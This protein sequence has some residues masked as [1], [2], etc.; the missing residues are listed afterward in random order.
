MKASYGVAK[1]GGYELWLDAVAQP[2]IVFYCNNGLRPLPPAPLSALR[3]LVSLQGLPYSCQM[4]PDVSH[5]KQQNN[6][7]R[8]RP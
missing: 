6:T 7:L 5:N 2:F 4:L 1:E 3:V 8:S